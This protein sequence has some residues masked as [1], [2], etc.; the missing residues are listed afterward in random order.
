MKGIL[1]LPKDLIQKIAI[2]YLYDVESFA[3][4][5]PYFRRCIDTGN[6]HRRNEQFNY[7]NDRIRIFATKLAFEHII[8]IRF[9]YK[10]FKDHNIQFYH[11][12]QYHGIIMEILRGNE[13]TQ[14]LFHTY[15]IKWS[16]CIGILYNI[17]PFGLFDF[18]YKILQYGYSCEYYKTD[19]NGDSREY[20]FN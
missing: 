19:E 13:I 14:K 2:E 10:D 7:P 8:R 9:M 12:N 3:Q 11:G 15:P 20:F 6:I 17:S 5:H 4:A 18:V 16:Q 1:D